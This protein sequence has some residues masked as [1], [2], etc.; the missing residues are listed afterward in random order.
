MRK[1]STQA[2]AIRPNRLG[3]TIRTTAMGSAANLKDGWV[4]YLSL[5]VSVGEDGTIPCGLEMLEF[6]PIHTVSHV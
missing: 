4:K 1:N 3:F 2:S 5:W 6:E